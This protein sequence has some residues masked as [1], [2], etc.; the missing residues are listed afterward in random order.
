MSPKRTP[1]HRL[2]FR[3][4][5]ARRLSPTT[6]SRT[7]GS[8]PGRARL[9]AL[10]LLLALGWACG[11]PRERF[12]GS[13]AS[14]EAL[15]QAFLGELEIGDPAGL[16]RLA[17]SEEEYRLELLPEMFAYGRVP[18]SFVWNQMQSRSQVGMKTVLGRLGGRSLAFEGI[19][20][21]GGTVEYQTFRVHLKPTVHVRDR[22]T[23]RRAALALFGSV[24]EHEGGFKLVSL[25]TDR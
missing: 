24:L 20:F 15:T 7:G 9:V 12:A 1:E 14:P 17:L 21:A 6:R 4:I 16:E 23:G 11:P 10:A 3:R 25:N 13:F 22:E 19:E 8:G 18:A 2:T 5:R